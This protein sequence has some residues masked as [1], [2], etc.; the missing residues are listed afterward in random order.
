MYAAIMYGTP[1]YGTPH[2]SPVPGHRSRT[3]SSVGHWG[4]GRLGQCSAS[5]SL[6]RPSGCQRLGVPVHSHQAISHQCRT[7]TRRKPETAGEPHWHHWLT[8]TVC[9]W[10]P[11]SGE[12]QPEWPAGHCQSASPVSAAPLPVGVSVPDEGGATATL[13][14]ADDLEWHCQWASA[15]GSKGSHAAVCQ[16]HY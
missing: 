1:Y 8:G 11:V 16:C 3:D 5:A 12:W 6:I 15:T 13:P 14:L 10:Q 4:S 7:G 9:H 2:W